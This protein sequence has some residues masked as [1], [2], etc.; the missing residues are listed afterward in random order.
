MSEPT[1]TRPL[2]KHRYID[3]LRRLIAPLHLDDSGATLTEF[4]IALPIFVMIFSSVML[5][6]EFTRK[7]TETPVVAYKQTFG[8]AL[9]FQK[10]YWTLDW[11]L[12]PVP[13][14]ADAADQLAGTG[15]LGESSMAHNHSTAVKVTSIAT[16]TL[17]YTGLGARGHLGESYARA[18]LMTVVPGGDVY[19]CDSLSVE[20]PSAECAKLND[21]T[22]GGAI[23]L[24]NGWLVSDLKKITGP[25]NGSEYAFDLLN[26][27]PSVSEFVKPSGGLWGKLNNAITGTGIRPAIAAGIR[28]GTVSR[29]VKEDFSF[30]GRTMTFDAHFSTLVPPSAQG[31][32]LGPVIDATRATAVTRATMQAHPH[33]ADLLGIDW[34]QPL[35]SKTIDVPE[36]DP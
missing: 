24:S 12:G 7:G 28:Y 32:T 20:Y 4:V 22:G 10:S 2:M 29:R 13:A 18:N 16:E 3:R 21:S 1:P 30:A 25:T 23:G 6:G 19:G 5:L 14:A 17:A 27:G 9:R 15:F 26:D 36:Y 33:Y 11:N 34:N 8:E 31:G 35:R